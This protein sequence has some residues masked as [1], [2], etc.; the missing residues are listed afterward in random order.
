MD[1]PELLVEGYVRTGNLYLHKLRGD[2]N[3]TNVVELDGVGGTMLLV[4]ADIHRQGL[5]FPPAPY[6]RRIETE[7]LAM[8]AR[9]MGH[10][11]WGMPN[12]E[13]IHK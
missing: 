11:V 8:M 10:S 2:G 3:V 1:G 4:D 7:G 6:R 9:D 12:L 13:I 5:V